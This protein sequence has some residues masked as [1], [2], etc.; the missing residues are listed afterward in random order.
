MSRRRHERWYSS[1]GQRRTR[2]AAEQSSHGPR[3]LISLVILLVLTLTMLH[4]VSDPKR[5][6]RVAG[7]VGLFPNDAQ[8]Q[9]AQDLVPQGSTLLRPNVRLDSDQLNRNADDLRSSDSADPADTNTAIV[10]DLPHGVSTIALFDP[11]NTVQSQSLILQRL[12]QTAPR[13]VFEGLVQHWLGLSDLISTLDS[14]SPLD[15]AENQNPIPSSA[16]RLDIDSSEIQDWIQSAQST[17]QRWLELSDPARPEHTSLLELHRSLTAKRLGAVEGEPKRGATDSEIVLDPASERFRSAMRLCLDRMLLQS[18]SDNTPWRTR[19]RLALSR[20]TARAVAMHQAAREGWLNAAMLPGVSIPQLTSQTASLRGKGIRLSGR[21]A[22]IDPKASIALSS[23][24][25]QNYDVLWLRPDDYSNQPIIIHVPE[26]LN[27]PTDWLQVDQAVTVA[28]IVAKRRAYASSRG[29]EVAPVLI[30]AIIEPAAPPGTTAPPHSPLQSRVTTVLAAGRKSHAW[31]PPIDIEAPARTLRDRLGPRLESI[32]VELAPSLSVASSESPATANGLIAW[33]PFALSGPVLASLL[34]LQK[35][36][37]EVALLARGLE[38]VSVGPGQVVG[39][40]VGRVRSIETFAIEQPPFP[41]WEWKAIYALHVQVEPRERTN[42][43]E[44]S[45]PVDLV[46]FLPN[47]PMA[48]LTEKSLNQPCVIEGIEI[49]DPRLSQPVSKEGHL[50]TT[51]SG[52]SPK[53][54]LGASIAW[55]REPRDERVS[56]DAILQSTSPPSVRDE[57]LSPSIPPSWERLLDRGWNLGWLDMLESLQGQ[58]MTSRESTAFYRLLAAADPSGTADGTAEDPLPSLNLMSVIQRSEGA[59]RKNGKI[60]IDDRSSGYRVQAVVTLRRVQ[61][62]EITNPEII[63]L[64]GSNAYYQIDGI[65]EIGRNRIEIRYGPDSEPV[66]FEKE[67]PVTLVARTV[68]DW[69]LVNSGD[70]DSAGSIAW[71]PRIRTQVEGWCYRTWK[72][73]TA[74]VSA[75]TDDKQFQQGPMLVID[76]IDMAN[77]IPVTNPNQRSTPWTSIVTTLL[78]LSGIG[79]FAWRYQMGIFPAKKLQKHKFRSTDSQ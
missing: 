11:D 76:R 28:G 69:I 31:S 35:F 71:Y 39:R 44:R 56:A 34:G 45:E 10:Q 52:S 16:A 58:S 4:Q 77:P 8:Q 79:W 47:V 67:F 75:A 54:V 13:P 73:K 22:R 15:S 17:L 62:I 23:Q 37:D 41:G 30:A 6:A 14:S 20:T 2:V 65:A 66:V 36:S 12:V 48:W 5:V 32:P 26:E 21:I 40:W 60:G 55:Q 74:Q 61:R 46:A 64:L 53:V 38:R 7:A 3:R 25:I 27:V 50:G 78:G 51:S 59:K 18:F 72:Y 24:P 43:G 29:G 1:E 63:E 33:K 42:H 9:P 70:T 49:L 68:P 57:P 19:E